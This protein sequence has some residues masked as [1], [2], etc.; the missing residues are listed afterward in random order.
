L[1][2]KSRL[3][4]AALARLATIFEFKVSVSPLGE[5]LSFA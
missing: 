1:I 4:V 5:F 2:I 3:N